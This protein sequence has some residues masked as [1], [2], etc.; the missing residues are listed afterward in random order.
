M[1]CTL[2]ILTN[3]FTAERDRSKAI[4]IWSG[5]TGLGVAVGPILGGILLTRYW[6]GSVFLINVPIAMAGLVAAAILVPNSKNPQLP[7]APTRSVRCCRWS[8]SV[9]FCGG[10]SKP[11]TTAGRPRFILGAFA[12]AAIII[13]C[14]VVWERRI[15]DPMLPLQFFR[16]RRYTAAIASLALVLFALLG[17]FFLITQY[18]QF[19]LDFTPLKT[20]LAILPLALVLLVVAPLSTVL[21]RQLRHQTGSRQRPARHRSRSRVAVEDHRRQHLP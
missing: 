9:S 17:M 1:P 11:P 3:V 6:W 19:C 20:G 21:A 8:G 10:S 7:S 15:D 4:G 14:F 5:T 2:S 16:N 18:L 13:G 12:G